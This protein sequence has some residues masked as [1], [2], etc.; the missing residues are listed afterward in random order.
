MPPR[1]QRTSFACPGWKCIPR[2]MRAPERDWLSWTNA[3]STPAAASASARK[4]SRKKP[5]SSP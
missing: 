3:D 4:L 5:R 1:T 2:M